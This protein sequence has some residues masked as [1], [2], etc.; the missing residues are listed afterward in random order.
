MIC[1]SMALSCFQLSITT[2]ELMLPGKM[3]LKDAL[4]KKTVDHAH[5]SQYYPNCFHICHHSHF[6]FFFFISKKKILLIEEKQE[7]YKEFTVVNKNNME[8]K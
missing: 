2:S 3:K 5:N 6:F 8:N 1:F 7:K 4:N